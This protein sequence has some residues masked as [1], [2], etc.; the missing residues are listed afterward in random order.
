MSDN[1]IFGNNEGLNRNQFDLNNVTRTTNVNRPFEHNSVFGN[2]SLFSGSS[3][4]S[5]LNNGTSSPVLGSQNLSGPPGLVSSPRVHCPEGLITSPSSYGGSSSFGLDV[6]CEIKRLAKE[7]EDLKIKNK[8]AI[9]VIERINRTIIDS[10]FGNITILIKSANEL[11]ETCSQYSN[12]RSRLVGIIEEERLKKGKE[13]TEKDMIIKSLESEITSNEKY[14]SDQDDEIEQIKKHIEL[15]HR[16]YQSKISGINISFD[17]KFKVDD[18]SSFELSNSSK[19]LSEIKSDLG[20]DNISTRKLTKGEWYKYS[21]NIC[22]DFSEGDKN[23]E[24]VRNKV[25]ML[26]KKASIFSKD[27][28]VRN[29]IIIP[30]SKS[31]EEKYRSMAYIMCGSHHFARTVLNKLTES[32]ANE[33]K[34]YFSKPS[35]EF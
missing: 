26:F 7:N 16:D 20:S 35:S 8:Q 33:V 9:D 4:N 24:S 25:Q 3:A 11:R 34:V 12:E 6:N 31:N 10:G 32:K 14:I 23:Y 29:H 13:I 17:R 5:I 18:D 30:K 19:D 15:L 1:M 22:I 27:F 2:Y 21:D 28:S